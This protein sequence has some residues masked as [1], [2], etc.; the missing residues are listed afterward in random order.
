MFAN[1]IRK[2][3]GWIAKDDIYRQFITMFD[4]FDHPVFAREALEEYLIKEVSWYI[5]K[6]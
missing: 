4:D 2:G 5:N 6:I 3:K 1:R